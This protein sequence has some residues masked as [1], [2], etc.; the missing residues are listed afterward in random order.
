MPATKKNL[1]FFVVVNFKR[2]VLLTLRIYF[3]SN[4]NSMVDANAPPWYKMVF[5]HIQISI[6]VDLFTLKVK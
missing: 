1:L 5:I 6:N 4:I 2:K 3:M